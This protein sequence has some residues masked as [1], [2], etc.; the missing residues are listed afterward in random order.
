MESSNA[1]VVDANVLI[2]SRGQFP[3]NKAV[4]PPSI[5]DEIKTD[6][7]R[8]KMQKL[9]LKIMRPS[10]QALEKVKNK[11][12]VINS[13]TS[14]QDEQAL[15]LALDRDITLITDDK[16]LQNLALHMGIDF[17]GFNE[18][19]VSEKRCWKNVCSNCGTEVSSLPCPHCGSQSLSRKRDQSS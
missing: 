6:L 12:D 1:A 16:A 13:P 14:T 18:Q 17:E 5:Q 7:S 2:H 4:I 3:V 11:S 8:M 15:A 19:K 10:Q 9:N